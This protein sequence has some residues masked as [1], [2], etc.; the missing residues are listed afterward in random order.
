MWFILGVVIG[1]VSVWFGKEQIAS[2]YNLAIN[3]IKEMT[4]KN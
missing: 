2:L 4:S 1:G 3:K